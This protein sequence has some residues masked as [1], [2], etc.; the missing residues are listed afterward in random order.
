MS[1][2]PVNFVVVDQT[3]TPIENV[4]VKVFDPTGAT[5][6]TEGQTNTSGTVSFLLQTQSY[7][8]RFFKQQMSF[9]Q[10]QLFDVL[11]APATNTFDVVGTVFVPPT[12]TDPRFCK[13]SGYFRTI[14]G[15]PHQGMD[16]HFRGLFEYLILENNG[17]GDNKVITRTDK[18]GFVCIDLIRCARYE[19]TLQDFEDTPRYIDVPDQATTNLPDLLFPTVGRITFSPAGP[20]TI[21]GVG[22]A[23][24]IT[25]TPS[26][27]T[28]DG[29]Q[30]EGTT[31][32]NVKWSTE[33]ETI[34]VVIPGTETLTLRG[35]TP[36][37]TKLVATRVDTSI[38]RIPDSGIIGVPVDLEVL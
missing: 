8:A 31:T 26:V 21:P 34:A 35:T 9:S 36:G 7:S 16:L 33:D 18:D 20:F 38:V 17:I 28:R 3:A 5:V 19:V 12:P 11:A 4:L 15:A 14:S 1:F 10:P 24:E 2:E 29:R 37:N 27:F 25:V 13:A 6:F 22:V 23:N 30:L 32:A